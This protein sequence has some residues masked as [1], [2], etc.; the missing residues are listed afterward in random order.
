MSLAERVNAAMEHAKLT[1]AQL[2]DAVGVKQQTIQ[3]LNYDRFVG[4]LR[5]AKRVRIEAQFFQRPPVVLD[6]DVEGFDPKRIE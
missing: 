4:A 1:Q 5:K 2:A 6:F 3:K